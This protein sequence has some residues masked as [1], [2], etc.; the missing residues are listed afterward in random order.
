LL[1]SILRH[2]RLTVAVSLALVVLLA[3][4]YLVRL[5]GAGMM[6]M[7]GMRLFPGMAPGGLSVRAAAADFLLLTAMWIV[8]MVGMMLPSAAPTTLI[9]SAI[10]RKRGATNPFFGRT[11]LFVVAYLLV[12][13]AFS[14]AAAAAQTGLARTGHLS[15]EMATTSSILAGAIF[16]LAGLYELTP[17]KDR[18]LSHCRGPIDW[19]A[20]HWRPGM[21]GAFRMGL[22][23]GVF[24]L[25]CCW[26]LMLLLFVGGVMNLL[27]VAAL[28]ALVLVQK[29]LPGGKLVARIGGAVL[30]LCGVYLVARPLLVA[31]AV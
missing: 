7:P 18:C 22:T 8:M 5:A 11:A 24:C 12:W 13:A 10:E 2:D 26:A 1:R 4:L 23:H 15:M 21:A 6:D 20:H 9:V 25:G 16:V 31:A 27:W 29:L 19:I 14:V 17:L 28:A 3:W 30:I